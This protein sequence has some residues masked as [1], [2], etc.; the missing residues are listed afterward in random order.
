M[1]SADSGCSV[2]ELFRGVDVARADTSLDANEH[3]DT[4][5]YTPFGSGISL[6]DLT[7]CQLPN[8]SCWNTEPSESPNGVIG[9]PFPTM[10]TVN[11]TTA[12]V[13]KPS[14]MVITSA[15]KQLEEWYVASMTGRGVEQPRRNR[16]TDKAVTGSHTNSG[17]QREA[18]GCQSL[19]SGVSDYHAVQTPSPKLMGNL[20]DGNCVAAENQEKQLIASQQMFMHELNR[21]PPD[22]RKHYVDYMIARHLGLL[23]GAC[24]T[25]PAVPA[26]YYSVAVGPS[27]VPV[28]QMFAHPVIMPTGPLMPTPLITLQPLVPAPANKSVNR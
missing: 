22:L 1:H 9:K 4:K 28:T 5:Y 18:V 12:A 2:F 13:T 26:M 19:S 11:K 15:S 7:R 3:N 17:Q 25:V 6:G 14:D 16:N 27:T 24:P 10:S 21:L 8:E 20:S 23:H